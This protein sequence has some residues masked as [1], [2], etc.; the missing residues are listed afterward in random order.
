MKKVFIILFV[1]IN[2]LILSSCNKNEFVK[3][4]IMLEDVFSIS[5]YIV[6]HGNKKDV[7][8][9]KDSIKEEVDKILI[10]LDSKYDNNNENSL[11]SK[12]NRE[13]DKKEVEIDEETYYI[14]STALDVSLRTTVSG[15]TKYDITV[16]P[17]IKKWDFVNKYYDGIHCYAPPEVN[18]LMALKELV[19]YGNIEL[20]ENSIKFLQE[21]MMI[22]LGSIVKGYACDKVAKYMDNNYPNLS[23]IL[24]IGGNVLTRGYTQRNGQVDDFHVAIQTPFEENIANP[25]A[26]HIG[27]IKASEGKLL[28]VVTSGIYER[29]IMDFSGN[30]YHHILDPETGYPIDNNV[31]SV[32][33]VIE[34]RYESILADA[35][36]TAMFDM[37]FNI[38]FGRGYINYR[39][40]II[41]ITKD[42]KIYVTDNLKD[43]FVLNEEIKEYYSY[44]EDTNSR[45]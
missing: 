31:E 4:T 34:D 37:D 17:L 35:Y 41:L 38:L 29:Y 32:T 11:I 10:E 13:A 19:Y 22:D 33:I 3:E 21:G 9:N 24:N 27:Y 23:Y 20:K 30:M 40:G 14:I 16:Y 6:L 15:I 45:K 39:I 8:N 2:V 7:N 18:E 12:I 44:Q 25:N 5:P 26:H 42:K 28:T 43:R 36:S 1:M